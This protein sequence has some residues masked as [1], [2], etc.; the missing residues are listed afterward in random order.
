MEAAPPAERKSLQAV[1]WRRRGGGEAEGERGAWDRRGREAWTREKSQGLERVAQ[2]TP[3]MGDGG[4]SCARFV[5]CY[6]THVVVSMCETSPSTR[7]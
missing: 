2:S 1:E 7:E 5:G 4:L 3:S 6:P